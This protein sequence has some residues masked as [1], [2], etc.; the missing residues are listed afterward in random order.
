M[1][2]RGGG[3]TSSL[4]GLDA[5]VQLDDLED[6]RLPGELALDLLSPCLPHSQAEVLVAGQAEDRVGPALDELVPAARGYTDATCLVE[7]VC[8]PPPTPS[9]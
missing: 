5:V 9:R 8:G 6:L 2:C 3:L 1:R 7:V 4:G